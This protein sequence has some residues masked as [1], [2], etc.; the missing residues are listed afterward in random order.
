[1]ICDNGIR[2]EEATPLGIKLF[3]LITRDTYSESFMLKV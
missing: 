1:M 2:V 3:A